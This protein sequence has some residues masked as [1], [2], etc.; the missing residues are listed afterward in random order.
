MRMRS[1]TP[2]SR[3]FQLLCA[4]H[5][6]TGTRR[7]CWTLQMPLAGAVHIQSRLPALLTI[8]KLWTR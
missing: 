5:V 8:A 4:L 2:L 3:L 7:C 6:P 1:W